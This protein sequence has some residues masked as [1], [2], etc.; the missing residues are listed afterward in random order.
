MSS[1]AK[2]RIADTLHKSLVTVL[3]GVSVVG[4]VDIAF[5][6]KSIMSAGKEAQVTKE[7]EELKGLRDASSTTSQ[8]IPFPQGTD[9]HDSQTQAQR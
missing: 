3:L 8:A 6:H 7:L 2:N 5:M 9:L 1:S 4:L